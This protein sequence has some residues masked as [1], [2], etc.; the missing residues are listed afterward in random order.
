MPSET[1]EIEVSKVWVDTEEQKV[2]RP[3]NIKVQ[4][5]NGETVVEE[6]EISNTTEKVTFENL[7]KY[8]AD[9]NEINYTI[10][11]AEVNEGDLKFYVSSIEGNT[12]TNTFTVPSE[13]INIEVTKEW[14]DNNNEAVKRPTS[15]IIVAK[16][17]NNVIGQVELTVAN[18]LNGNTNTWVGQIENLPKYDSNGNIIVYE[19]DEIEKNSGDLYFYAKNVNGNRIINTLQL[20]KAKYKVEHYRRTEDEEVEGYICEV[21]YFEEYPGKFVTAVPKDY[22]GFVENT[23]HPNRIPSG[24]VAA[25]GSL[26]LKLY[27]NRERYNI[28]YVLNGGTAT[29]R[30]QNKYTYGEQVYLSKKVEKDGFEF[31]GWYDNEA[32]IGQPVLEISPGETGDKVF[33]AKWRKEVISSDKYNIDGVEKYISK[34]SPE[35]TVN[36][37]IQNMQIDGNIKIYDSKGNEVA[38]NKFV[39]TGYKAVV[40][41]DGETYEYEIAVRGDLDG[42]GKVTATDLSTLNQAIIKKIKLEGVKALA[43]D[44]DGNEKITATDLSTLNQAVIKKIKL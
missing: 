44:I 2:H 15:I 4:I 27:Y 14:V 23:S 28:T 11:E 26:V 17:G 34:V 35:T 20:E 32:C 9:G 37:F 10:A 12:I 8:D 18:A 13:T 1:V 39:G 16:S 33:Y 22:E 38:P 19:I 29:G 7:P 6:K 3:S 31:G 24:I 36:S 43:A 5:K 25:D 40:E 30:L 21:E 42:N 41:K